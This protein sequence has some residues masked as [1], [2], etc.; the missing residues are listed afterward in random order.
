MSA[1][2]VAS[3]V[4]FRNLSV[5]IR[6]PVLRRLR[7]SFQI[8]RLLLPVRGGRLSRCQLGLRLRQVLTCGGDFGFQSAL[9]VQARVDL[10][11]DLGQ[12]R[13]GVLNLGFDPFQEG[14][15]ILKRADPVFG[16][17]DIS[18][19]SF[20]LGRPFADIVL[21]KLKV[22]AC[23]FDLRLKPVEILLRLLRAALGS[24]RLGALIVTCLL[25]GLQVT[26]GGVQFVFRLLKIGCDPVALLFEAGQIVHLIPKLVTPRFQITGFVP[27]GG[28]AGL[29]LLDLT[30]QCRLLVAHV[31]QTG[32]SLV[33]LDRGRIAVCDLLLG[34]GP[35]GL[36]RLQRRLCLLDLGVQAL[37]LAD[38]GFRPRPLGLQL[39]QFGLR[40]GDVRTKRGTFLL[41]LGNLALDPGA[42]VADLAELLLQ[43][44]HEVQKGGQNRRRDDGA[45]DGQ[46]AKQMRLA[47]GVSL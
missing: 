43:T 44:D 47:H 42:V 12:P 10:L 40:A 41:P 30:L 31:V 23:L 17:L 2:T 32:L 26:S 7:G 4:C 38:Q 28:F 5:Q 11:I 6:K 27:G 1:V 8:L 20:Q 33:N 25:N 13:F 18:A 46:P 16:K 29:K 37:Q 22:R 14:F 9:F 19:Q 15:F 35:V 45:A 3:A 39:R 36:Q 24:S 34:I 21:G